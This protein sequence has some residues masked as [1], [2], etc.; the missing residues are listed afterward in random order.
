MLANARTKLAAAKAE[1]AKSL[2]PT[3]QL[4]R[5]ETR[6]G[7]AEANLNEAKEKQADIE[8]KIVELRKSLEV[9]KATVAE[10]EVLYSAAKVERDQV[11]AQIAHPE[12]PSVAGLEPEDQANM[13]KIFDALASHPELQ[14]SLAKL[15]AKAC[16]KAGQ[17]RARDNVIDLSSDGDDGQHPLD[18]DVQV[19]V[20]E[21]LG[22]AAEVLDEY[23]AESRRMARDGEGGRHGR[24]RSP[25]SS[26]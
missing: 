13:D 15:A 24:S 23:K 7:R 20:L 2:P 4:Q 1:L 5:C 3:V 12:E 16:P 21:R 19:S 14:L 11:A 18:M 6:L 25:R 22:V 10:R 8:S 26:G 9:C 17:K